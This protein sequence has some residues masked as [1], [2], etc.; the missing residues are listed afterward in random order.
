MSEPTAPVCPQCG[1]P[2]ATDGT[3]ACSCGRLASEAHR[4]I[5]TAQAEAAEDFDPVRIRPFVKVGDDTEPAASSAAPEGEPQPNASEDGDAPEA[6]PDEPHRAAAAPFDEEPFL[7]EQSPADELLP[8]DS[9]QGGR[10]RRRAVLAAGVGAGAAAVLVTGGII[11][12][13]FSYE[14]PARDGS[15]PGD[16]RADLPEAAAGEGTSS[17]AAA[18][19]RTTSSPSPSGT[20]STSP[21]ATPTESRATPTGSGTPTKSPSNSD[22]TVTAAPAPTQS[23]AQPP[24]LGLGD[25]GAEV[26]EL[27]LRLR[28]IGLYNGDAGGDYDRE[29]ESA[30]RGYQL[31]RA[32]L[33]DDPGVYGEATRA[34]LESE[35]SEP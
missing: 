4:D 3:P 30:V 7:D 34:S 26:T 22:A 14:A 17:S 1:T 31:T 6:A 25:R 23:D 11:G 12:G 19:S 18:P 10:R 33:E 15:G 5:R 29:V 28:Q 21:E 32:V 35:T 13:L 24:V 27:Q 20:S 2:R 16:V 8:V 9:V